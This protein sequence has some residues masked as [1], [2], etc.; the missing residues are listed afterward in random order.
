MRGELLPQVGRSVQE[1]PGRAVGRNRE[2]RLGTR[3]P[4]QG[5]IAQ[6]AAIAAGAIP[7]GKSAPGG[8]AENLDAHTGLQFRAG[9]GVEC[10]VQVHLF[11]LWRDLFHCCTP[12][13]AVIPP[14]PLSW[15]DPRSITLPSL[16]QEVFFHGALCQRYVSTA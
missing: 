7:L 13:R 3:A 9:G 16:P 15:R 8:G 4:A 5:A 2:L 14:R 10:A 6:P 1:E 11:V 12:M